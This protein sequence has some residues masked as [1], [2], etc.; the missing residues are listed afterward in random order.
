MMF[1]QQPDTNES[2]DSLMQM[3]KISPTSNTSTLVNNNLKATSTTKYNGSNLRSIFHDVN[4]HN[5]NSGNDSYTDKTK[6]DIWKLYN[7][8]D[9]VLLNSNRIL[10]FSWRLYNRNNHEMNQFKKMNRANRCFKYGTASN[11][12]IQTKDESVTNNNMNKSYMS[13]PQSFPG[14]NSDHDNNEEIKIEFDNMGL[15]VDF[16]SDI[17]S[18]SFPNSFIT[19]HSIDPQINSLPNIH[20]TLNNSNSEYVN[21]LDLDL[22]D[23][24]QQNQYIDH[25]STTIPLQNVNGFESCFD[26]NSLKNIQ[27]L[28]T[29][30]VSIPNQS[31]IKSRNPTTNLTQQR[32]FIFN[33]MT[34]SSSISNFDTFA[35]K[36][37]ESILRNGSNGSITKN[38]SKNFIIGSL[39]N[40]P[41]DNFNNNVSF[42]LPTQELFQSNSN[43]RNMDNS[44]VSA[45]TASRTKKTQRK[46]SMS[47]QR[48]R[49]RCSNCQ[50]Y[51]TPLWRKGPEGNPL[52]NACG[53]FLKLHGVMRPLSLKTDTIKKRQRNNGNNNHSTTDASGVS[54]S[55]GSTT[56]I[57]KNYSIKK[58]A[59]KEKVDLDWLSLDL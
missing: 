25:D 2:W 19:D 44:I 27:I 33:Y 34:P 14:V 30:P 51:N 7:Q 45:T 42:S 18:S 3:D 58:V 22:S 54:H 24:D 43:S 46:N 26:H 49:T 35:T 40:N 11:A 31:I 50:T 55:S 38:R 10:N 5:T 57:K 59:S 17:N 47:G 8:A 41:N 20:N 52:C 21:H 16:N 23:M 9:Q 32:S 1:L 13:F 48:E 28:T 4:T 36:N 6:Q 39:N 37:G 29:S 15:N 12:S 53:L 56:N